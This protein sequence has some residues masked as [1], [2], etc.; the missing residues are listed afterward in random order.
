MKAN[1]KNILSQIKMIIIDAI[2][3]V[4]RNLFY[5]IHTRII[6][7]FMYYNLESFAWLSIVLLSELFQ[8]SRIR[9]DPIYVNVEDCDNL[10]K[11]FTLNL[12]YIFKFA[13]MTKVMKEQGDYD[14][15]TLLNKIHT[16]YIDEI[17]Q[18]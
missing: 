17:I 18:E 3:T 12:W 13:E 14:F 4:F 6:K 2:S 5:K 7:I 9:G 15:V 16:D 10:E 1:L 11:L 8:L